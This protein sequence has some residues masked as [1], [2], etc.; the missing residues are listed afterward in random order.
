M[1]EKEKTKAAIAAT[2]ELLRSGHPIFEHGQEAVE[3]MVGADQYLAC[4]QALADLL[5]HPEM[6]KPEQILEVCDESS[7]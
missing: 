1:S 5:G 6:R 4:L 7:C 2:L 3:Y